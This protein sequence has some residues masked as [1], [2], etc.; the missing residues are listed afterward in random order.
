VKKYLFF[1]F[2]VEILLPALDELV[3]LQN[4]KIAK[5]GDIIFFTC[6]KYERINIY[7]ENI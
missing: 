4:D 2:S 1:S 5:F 7:F 6:I 3:Q